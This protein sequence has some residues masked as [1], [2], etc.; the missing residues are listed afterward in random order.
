MFQYPY[1][2]EEVAHDIILCT[3]LL[4]LYFWVGVIDD[5]EEHVQQHKEHEEDVC[6][7][8]DG[9]EN[10]VRLCDRLVVEVTEDD[11]ELCEAWRKVDIRASI[12]TNTVIT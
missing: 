5:G 2:F 7:E 4:T 1:R 8:P 6:D 12:C 9:A 3:L 11:T 10:T